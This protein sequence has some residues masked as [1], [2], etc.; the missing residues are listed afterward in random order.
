M[1][2]PAQC[3]R[4][5]RTPVAGA[6]KEDKLC[7]RLREPVRESIDHR[8]DRY[9]LASH[10]HVELGRQPEPLLEGLAHIHQKRVVRAGQKFFSSC[11]LNS[12]DSWFWH[13]SARAPQAIV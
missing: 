6:A 11:G 10:L 12:T 5:L 13:V 9:G 4:N 8:R 1:A 2:K 7:L 3:A